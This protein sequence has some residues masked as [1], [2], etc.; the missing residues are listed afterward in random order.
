VERKKC[1]GLVT[2]SAHTSTTSHL[3]GASHYS[4]SVHG[5]SYTSW[6]ERVPVIRTTYQLKY[7]CKH[8]GWRWSEEQVEQVEDFD[9]A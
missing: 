2:R 7:R 4:G 1:S 5:S 9:R 8:C 6:Q 3:S